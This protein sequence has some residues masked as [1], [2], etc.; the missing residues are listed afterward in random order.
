MATEPTAVDW[1]EMEAHEKLLSAVEASFLEA[2]AELNVIRNST[3]R[4]R[5]SDVRQR[6]DSA[7]T[8]L[9]KAQLVLVTQQPKQAI[10]VVQV[11]NG[12]FAGVRK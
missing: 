1:Q 3:N 4:T 9:A 11:K 5:V 10:E 12:V 7:L 8:S 2:V 6:A